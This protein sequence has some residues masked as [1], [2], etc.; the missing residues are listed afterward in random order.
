MSKQKKRSYSS[1]KR[2]EGA[3]E[4]R[5]RILRV[6]KKLFQT[7]GFDCVTIDQLAEASA[8]SSPTIYSLFKSKRGL[9]GAVID[10]ALSSEKRLALVEEEKQEKS[11]KKRLE[12]AAKIT[13]QMYEAE[14][15][16]TDLFRGAS[17]LSPELKKLER[18]REERRYE[19]QR[20]SAERMHKEQV[21]IKGMEITEARDILWA[22]T[23]RDLYRLFTVERGWS[24]SRYEKWLAKLLIKTLIEE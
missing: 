18:Q 12:I 7:E 19:R 1:A 20:K 11:P 3:V 23:G 14:K 6:A 21:L 2:K 8:V 4:T 16:Q 22:F 15:L 17:V 13:R 10:E 24:P 9:L 5:K